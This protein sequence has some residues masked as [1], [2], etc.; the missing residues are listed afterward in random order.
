MLVLD[1]RQI[2]HVGQIPMLRRSRMDDLRRHM[3]D[4]VRRPGIGKPEGSLKESCGLHR[5]PS[6][7]IRWLEG[8]FDGP[9]GPPL[10]QAFGIKAFKIPMQGEMLVPMTMTNRHKRPSR[11]A[12]R[13][14]HM[15]SEALGQARCPA[16]SLG[17]HGDEIEDQTFEP[18]HL[19]RLGKG[20]FPKY[21]K[22]HSREFPSWTTSSHASRELKVLNLMIY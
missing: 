9:P 11:R 17:V 13:T 6:A 22:L 3:D 10:A 19:S 16:H 7:E 20:E 2:H 21:E 8:P 1:I 15:A 12:N 18:R 5:A 14:G 4:R